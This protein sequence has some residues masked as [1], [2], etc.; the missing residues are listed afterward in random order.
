MPVPRRV[1]YKTGEVE[2]VIAEITPGRLFDLA[3]DWPG[4]IT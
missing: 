4:P 3:E 1:G 2:Y